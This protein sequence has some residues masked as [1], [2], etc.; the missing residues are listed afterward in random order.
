[1]EDS[2]K[3]P[4]RFPD[5]CMTEA[6]HCWQTDDLP[7]PTPCFKRAG[8]IP[9]TASGCPVDDA[10]DAL[11]TKKIAVTPYWINL[12]CHSICRISSLSNDNVEYLERMAAQGENHLLSILE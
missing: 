12:L 9:C 3:K 7:T 4:P 6:K 11:K 10:V 2:K 1:M 8:G 5:H